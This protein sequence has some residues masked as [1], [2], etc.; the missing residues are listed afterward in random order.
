HLDRG[1]SV[2]DANGGMLAEILLRPT[3][4]QTHAVD[5][6]AAPNSSSPLSSP[7]DVRN[8]HLR[9]ILAGLV[10]RQDNAAAF[11]SFLQAIDETLWMANHL[12]GHADQHMSV[13]IGR[14]LALVRARLQLTLGGDPVYNQSWGATFDE[15]S[16]DLTTTTFGWAIFS[17]A[18]MA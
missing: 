2:Y 18:T 16:G 5:W 15:D 11:Q 6:L 14:P 3:G 13:L 7:E 10:N 17:S 1:V 4:A 8:A 12:G 9:S